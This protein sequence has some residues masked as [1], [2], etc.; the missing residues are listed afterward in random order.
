MTDDA[1][2]TTF[3]CPGVLF[4]P[5][6]ADSCASGKNRERRDLVGVL[7]KKPMDGANCIFY[8]IGSKRA[9]LARKAIFQPQRQCLQE[10][11]TGLEMPIHR[12]VGNSREIGHSLN[13]KIVYAF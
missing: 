4:A 10:L 2:E 13:G 6:N 8:L 12:A 7:F 5:R 9:E 1:G 11:F 3:H